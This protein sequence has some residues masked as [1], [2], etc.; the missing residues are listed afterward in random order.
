MSFAFN[1]D[2]KLLAESADRFVLDDYTFETRRGIMGMD[3]GFSRDV[4]AQFADLGWLALP[5]PEAHGGIGGSTVDTAVLLESLGRGLIVEPYHGTVV[6][7]A[8]AV[9]TAGNE[10]Q[11]S[12]ILPAVAEGK[13]LLAFA[14]IEPRARFTL[15]HV[16]VTAAKE[17]AGYVL[18]GE[19]AVVHNAETADK[20]IVSARTAG[21]A[22]DE[23]GVT[24][25]LIDRSA[26]GVE[27]RSYPTIDGLRASEIMLNNVKVGADAVLGDVDGAMAAIEAV[28]DRACVL[29][30]AEAAGAMDVA[31]KLTVDY[32]KTR[33]QFGRPIG[34]FQVLQHR[35]VEMLGAKEYSRALTYR[36][37]GVVDV[38][39]PRERARAVSAAKVE[40]G[41]GGKK[42]GQDGVQLHGGMGM[43]EDMA[44]GHYFKRLT[45]IDMLF[46]NTDHHMRRFARLG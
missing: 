4:W 23:A 10:A 8:G 46:G 3:G 24:L 36:A 42:I 25:F 40:M 6:M 41:R 5:I 35:A 29:M 44:V 1:D 19:K 45:M 31:V 11:K 18:N 13:T 20:L 26:D 2:Q 28:V 12:E 37:A 17:G 9:A 15:S 16:E 38:A 27:L 22:A 30:C 14:H 43:T 33:V 39:D 32:M 34:E 7:G 21:G